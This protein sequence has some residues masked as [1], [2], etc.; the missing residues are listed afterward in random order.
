MQPKLNIFCVTGG[1][2]SVRVAKCEFRIRLN[3]F[4]EA[5][6]F[7]CLVKTFCFHRIH[8]SRFNVL[9]HVFERLVFLS[10]VYFYKE[11]LMQYMELVDG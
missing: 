7:I 4:S 6:V 2:T 3:S 5:P 1:R 8:F 9:T 10:H 11:E